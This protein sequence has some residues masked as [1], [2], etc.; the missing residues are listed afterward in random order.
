MNVFVEAVGWDF[1]SDCMS[2]FK[3]CMERYECWGAAD[4]HNIQGLQS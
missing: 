4:I 1:I 2:S 3:P